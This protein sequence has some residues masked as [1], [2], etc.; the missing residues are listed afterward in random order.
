MSHKHVSSAAS[1]VI[2]VGPPRQRQ[3]WYIRCQCASTPAGSWPISVCASSCTAASTDP[4]AP[5][6]DASPHPNSP[7]SVC[8]RTNS[9][10]RQ[11]TQ[12]LKVSTRVIRIALSPGSQRRPRRCGERHR[13]RVRMI[14]ILQNV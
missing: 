11:C 1:A 7:S 10:L 12:Y 14:H 6:S 9:Q 13:G 8:R 2:R 3:A 5:C 4:T